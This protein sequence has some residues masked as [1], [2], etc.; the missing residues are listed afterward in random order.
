MGGGVRVQSKLNIHCTPFTPHT[1]TS[2]QSPPQVNSTTS[3]PPARSPAKRQRL[4][5][6][7]VPSVSSDLGTYIAR[8]MKLLNELGW[9]NL[10]NPGVAEEISPTSPIFNIPQRVSS[11]TTRVTV[12]LSKSLPNRGPSAGYALPS[13]E[14]PTRAATS[15]SSS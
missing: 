15:T 4:Q 1:I 7:I 9:K 3:L 6:P 8:D 5:A 2:L 10:F 13:S 12:P 14:G 11:S